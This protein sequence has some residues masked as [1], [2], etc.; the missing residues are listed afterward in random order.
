MAVSVLAVGRATGCPSKFWIVVYKAPIANLVGP[1]RLFGVAIVAFPGDIDNRCMRLVRHA[2]LFERDYLTMD[3]VPEWLNGRNVDIPL[4]VSRPCTNHGEAKHLGSKRAKPTFRSTQ[5]KRI[6]PEVSTSFTSLRTGENTRVKIVRRYPG[7][8]ICKGFGAGVLRTLG[9]MG[10]HACGW[11]R[12]CHRCI[13][14]PPTGDPLH[15]N[16]GQSRR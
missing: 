5:K 2:G 3:R 4:S 10:G 6:P 8:M 7:E 16:L 14:K 13:N 11:K 1:F 15:G 9:V 12:R